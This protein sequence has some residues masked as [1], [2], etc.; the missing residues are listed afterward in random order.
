MPLRCLDD[1]GKDLHAFDF[2][3]HDWRNLKAE[4]RSRWHLRMPCCNS[5]VIAKTSRLGT[6]FFAHK[7]AGLCASAPEGEAHWDLKRLVVMAARAAGWQADTEVSGATP[8]GAGWK[9]DVLAQKRKYRVAIEIQWSGQTNE[10]TLRRQQRYKD[11]GIRGLWLLRQPGFPVTRELPA[12][13]I[14][15][16]LEEGFLAL[17]PGSISTTARDRRHPSLWSQAFAMEAFLQAVFGGRF[18]FGLPRDGEATVFLFGAEDDCW[19]CGA[20]TLVVSRIEICFGP[21]PVYFS[22]ANFGEFPDLVKVLLRHL[23]SDLG[24]GEI[25]YRFSKT[26][27]EEYLSNG[28]THCGQLY[29]R[30][31]AFSVNSWARVLHKFSI[32]ID[33]AWRQAI[34]NAWSERWV[35]Y[36]TRGPKNEDLSR[37]DLQDQ[38]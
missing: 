7:V 18:R 2:D 34:E 5:L 9:A 29:G 21:S 13:C 8:T 15:G 11:S 28:C 10:E 12:I 17:I 32:R 33:A 16:N 36:E 30:H 37:D 1:A 24:L 31:Y 38:D 14:G 35:V 27:N 26:M 22:L 19:A 20:E 6:Q 4:N 23:P 3:P 25:K